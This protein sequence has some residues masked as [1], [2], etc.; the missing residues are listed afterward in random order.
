M[1]APLGRP[2]GETKNAPIKTR[3]L[4]AGRAG[5]VPRQG[6]SNFIRLH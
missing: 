2:V 5:R 6:Y 3:F 4:L 1:C